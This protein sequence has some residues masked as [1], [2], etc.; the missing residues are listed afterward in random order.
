MKNTSGNETAAHSGSEHYQ[1]DFRY[2]RKFLVSGISI[3]EA[4]SL[5]R[6]H[7]A[8]FSRLFPPRFINNVYFDTPS[9]GHYRDNIAGIP[10]RTKVRIRWYGSQFGEHQT[11]KLEIKKK[12]GLLGEKRLFPLQGIRLNPG[13]HSNCLIKSLL[14][15]GLPHMIRPL[16]LPVQPVLFNRYFR[17]YWQSADSHFRLTIDS[18]MSYYLI[19]RLSNNFQ[20]SFLDRANLVIELKY[21]DI[22]D[23]NVS[24]IS[25]YFPFRLSKNSKYVSGI[26]LM[27]N[28]FPEIVTF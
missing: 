14:N 23:K 3:H 5:I 25:D 28:D 19:G 13:F 10:D 27:Y 18:D 26:Q 8:H 9:F 11:A 4:I 22:Q 7:P 17:S 20:K 6:F 2:E 12:Q 24:R 1:S 21:K 16:L 15:S